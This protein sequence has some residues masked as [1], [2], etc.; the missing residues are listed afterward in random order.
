MQRTWSFCSRVAEMGVFIAA[1]AA[2]V[3]GALGLR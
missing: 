1:G 2:L 3:F